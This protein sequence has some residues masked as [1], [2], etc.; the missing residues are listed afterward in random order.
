M[1]KVLVFGA[2]GLLGSQIAK[3]LLNSDK[4]ELLSPSRDLVDLTSDIQVRDYVSEHKPDFIINCAGYN[5][6]DQC[7]IDE[8]QQA[9]ALKL[10][11][12][13]PELLS[14][15]ALEHG[16]RFVTF[17]TDYVFD[18]SK[19]SA[20]VESDTPNPI[21]YYGKTK[22][23]AEQ[24]VLAANPQALVIR[25]QWLFGPGRRDFV[26]A[27]LPKLE[28]A[29]PVPVVN[30]QIGCPT[31]TVDLAAR[32]IDSVLE[33]DTFGIV[34]LVNQGQVS[35]Y[36]FTLA[37]QETLGTHAMITP[38]SSEGFKR[39]AT[40]PKYGILASEKIEQL[41]DFRLA[42]KDYLLN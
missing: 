9:M 41:R 16:A 6:V 2:N 24:A 11:V 29:D 5:L 26:D 8:E 38:V 27:I 40:R 23:M 28:G 18:G 36:E 30:D 15:L 39:L 14:K 4:Y 12:H 31:Y 7:E 1:H 35:W 20:Y 32:V 10:N 34:H 19:E 13:A 42:L 25:T 37:I 21:N 33:S 22:L 17:S 3:Q